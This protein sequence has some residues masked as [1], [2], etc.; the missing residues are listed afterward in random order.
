MPDIFWDGIVPLLKTIFG[1]PD[2]EKLIISE[3]NASFLAIKT[4]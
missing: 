4:T 1:Q 3:E 2:D